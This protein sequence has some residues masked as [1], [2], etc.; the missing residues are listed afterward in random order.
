MVGQ[1]RLWKAGHHTSSDSATIMAPIAQ[2]LSDDDVSAVTTYL[3][4]LGA[5]PARASQP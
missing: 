1:L 5:A 4:G 3:S 2:R